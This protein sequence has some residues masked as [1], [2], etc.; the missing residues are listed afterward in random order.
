MAGIRVEAI[1][2]I[3]FREQGGEKVKNVLQILQAEGNRASAALMKLSGLL[4]NTSYATKY[5]KAIEQA[6]EK[7]REFNE[8]Q[9]QYS[10][11]SEKK[12]PL[13]DRIK[14]LSEMAAKLSEINVLTKQV[15]TTAKG[16]FTD[17]AKRIEKVV[18]TYDRLRFTIEKSIEV[19]KRW[20]SG[21]NIA[22]ARALAEE[23]SRQ[24]VIV[25]KLAQKYLELSKARE[26]AFKAGDT[27]AVAKLSD[28]MKKVST[29]ID[30]QAAKLSH[31]KTQVR[32]TVEKMSALS[33]M[34]WLVEVSKRAFAYAGIFSGIYATFQAVE[35]ATKYAAEINLAFKTLQG[36]LKT[37][38]VEAKQLEEEFIRLGQVF[39]G[40]LEDINKVAYELGRAGIATKDLSKATKLVIQMAMLTGDSYQVASS[41]LITFKENFESS[42]ASMYKGQDALTILGNKIAYIANASRMTTQDIGTFAN[43]AVAAAKA[44][45]ATVD[46][47]GAMAVAFNNAG[48]NASTAGTMTRRF[49]N[50]L[51]SKQNDVKELFA[52]LGV[53]QDILLAK[54]QQG[55]QVANEAFAQFVALLRD[56]ND[57]EFQKLIS[58]MDILAKQT[59]LGLKN[60]A[61]AVLEHLQNLINTTSGELEGASVIADSYVKIWERF[62]NLIGELAAKIAD[63]GLENLT[64]TLSVILSLFDNDKV[65]SITELS[66]QYKELIDQQRILEQLVQKT[67]FEEYKEKLKAVN[68]E[69]E[70]L[71]EQLKTLNAEIEATKELANTFDYIV[72][73]LN[74]V[75]IAPAAERYIA[76]MKDA[77]A[78][79]DIERVI[80]AINA[81]LMS[82]NEEARKIA[83]QMLSIVME[84]EKYNDLVNSRILWH[85]VEGDYLAQHF[86]TT[87]QITEENR[88]N[89]EVLQFIS[90][91]QI[92]ILRS[93]MSTL[94]AY[95]D[96]LGQ[97]YVTGK[98]TDISQN[99]DLLI[100]QQQKA[101]LGVIERNSKD[102]TDAVEQYMHSLIVS[103]DYVNALIEAQNMLVTGKYKEVELTEKDKALL[104][105]LI[106]GLQRLLD[107]QKIIN[108]GKKLSTQ[109]SE[110]ETKTIQKQVSEYERLLEQIEQKVAVLRGE[111]NNSFDAR[112]RKAIQALEEKNNK[113]KEEIALLQR[114]KKEY[115]E[116]IKLENARKE[117]SIFNRIK[118][119]TETAS[120]NPYDKL[121]AQYEKLKE[122]T[123]QLSG[124]KRAEALQRIDE[125]YYQ[126]LDELNQRY[127]QKFE[128]DRLRFHN[129]Y[130]Q[131]TLEKDDYYFYQIGQKINEWLAKGI[132]SQQEAL[133]YALEVI[134]KKSIDKFMEMGNLSGRAIV[135]RFIKKLLSMKKFIEKFGAEVIVGVIRP[136]LLS[137]YQLMDNLF[138]DAITGR[139]KTF[140]DYIRSFF[141]SFARS[142]ADFL[143]RLAMNKLLMWIFG[144]PAFHTGGVVGSYGKKYHTGGTIK[145]Y[146]SGGLA[147]DEVP[148]IL[149]VGEG[150]LSRRGMQM[151]ALLNSGQLPQQN[152]PTKQE[153]I[154]VKIDAVD[155]QSFYELVNRNPDA[156]VMPIMRALKMNSALRYEVR[157]V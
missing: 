89:L 122:Q 74:N 33:R 106:G 28:E 86:N 109:L 137:M 82:Q 93:V 66:Q 16:L 152:Q 79:N 154:I 59:L 58:G 46:I 132:I 47:L 13:A 12:A 83:H 129:E 4:E 32:D 19:K 112:V 75:A 126:R 121:V 35:N 36:V 5:G 18:D 37:S 116:L 63:V 67:G 50:I 135:D 1:A 142:L 81:G 118:S 7:L 45:G 157:S 130:M 22:E 2:D 144:V 120:S 3:I 149:Q 54:L 115:K 51:T 143:T 29:E 101:L 39:G 148:A 124:E 153:T 52:G 127:I 42:I 64:E 88:K 150:V 140:K 80:S 90:D 23:L 71:K 24:E 31:Y 123:M 26:A 48:N 146:H 131:L 77:L 69:I 98:I 133:D 95:K 30:R 53:N 17:E 100:A 6:S 108:D 87:K 44:A 113:T 43:Y 91:E 151:L 138:F 102:M 34:K 56:I 21:K 76:L 61:S 156:I 38:S 73:S 128:E 55:G 62:K 41:A 147:D 49:F 25:K 14:V 94:R 92:K 99:A 84:N 134:K 78:S 72:A 139:L 117:N 110:Q 105:Q 27:Q 85:K 70:N 114:L 15:N 145:K 107:L 60:N 9:K 155:A 111:V 40:T 104:N 136:A 68:A 8:L 11:L 141:L 65:R 57:N 125:W 97:D 103:R 96:M 10:L 20:T 119:A